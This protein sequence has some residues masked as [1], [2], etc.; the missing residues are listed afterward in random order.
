M[1]CHV[2]TITLSIQQ[3]EM[4][5]KRAAEMGVGDRVHVHLRD[6]RDLPHSFEHAFDALISCEM[7]EVN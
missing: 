1:G 3:M 7:I 6:Y 2:D 5:L 4:V